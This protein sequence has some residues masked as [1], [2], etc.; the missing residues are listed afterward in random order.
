MSTRITTEDITEALTDIR[1][2]VPGALEQ[3][4]GKYSP[5]LTKL[6]HDLP[7]AEDFDDALSLANL[8]FV[9]TVR[10]PRTLPDT[11]AAA[12]Y[13]II[14]N[15]MKALNDRSTVT[16]PDGTRRHYITTMAAY[17]GDF[18]EAYDACLARET[19]M[20]AGTFL[21]AHLA[22]YSH[23]D[24]ETIAPGSTDAVNGIDVA[25]PY[26]LIDHPSGDDDADVVHGSLMPLLAAI[27]P[28]TE[29]IVRLAY[30]FDID[31]VA[32]QARMTDLGYSPGDPL[33]D[34]EVAEVLS[35]HGLGVRTVNRR[36]N[37]ALEAL[38]DHFGRK[39]RSEALA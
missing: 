2:D 30:G 11:T 24:R 37:E 28:E 8:A 38:R 23:T 31:D 26:S 6:A 25:D 29:L 7:G 33:S 32:V 3:F 16:I 12:F 1:D 21:A 34:I 9:E 20:A 5:I 22:A 18:R 27:S 4:F 13:V 39:T 35:R 10:D 36:R 14:R 17:D 15:R 19:R